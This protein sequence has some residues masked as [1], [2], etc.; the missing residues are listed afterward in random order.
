MRSPLAIAL[1]HPLNLVGLAWSVAA[2]LIAAWWLFPLGLLLWLIMVIIIANDRSLRYNYDM[3]ARTGTLSARFQKLYDQVM[4]SQS[5]IAK[6]LIS[7]G[8][9]PR[10][11]LAP[12]QAEVETLTNQVY[13]ACQQMT[14]PENYLKIA[15]SNS[16]VEG[17]RALLVL[18]LD[19]IADPVVKK[20]K[21]EALRAVESRAQ[22]NKAIAA[23]LDHMEAQLSTVVS[24]LDATLADVVRLQ[25]MGAAQAEKEMPKVLQQ[26]REQSAQL[27]AFED[28]AARVA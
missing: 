25:A 5:R 15:N 22:K 21:E 1:F 19:G 4:R 2:G 24:T 11:A 6:S 23:L 13:S 26:I 17:E 9:R 28:E 12:V 8:G 18:S 14:G 10:R 7:A 16:D 3:Q 27:K 20:E